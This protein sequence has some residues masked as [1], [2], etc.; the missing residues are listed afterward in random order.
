MRRRG[1]ILVAVLVVTVLVTMVAASLLFRM[2]A[3]TAA[4]AAKGRGDQAYEA[5]LSGLEFATAVLQNYAG[6]MD[7]WYDN[8]D[9][10]LNQLVA[11]DGAN[12]WYFTVY[13]DDPLGQ[14]NL[15]YG[16]SDESGKINLNTA[17]A[18]QLAGLAGLTEELVDCLLDYIDAD[19]EAR[20]EGAEQEYYDSLPHP[21]VIPNGPLATIEELLLVKGFDG[22]IVYGEDA[23]L[24]GRLDPNEDDGDETFPPDD[25]DGRL[26]QGLRGVATVYSGDSDLDSE[27]NARI[28]LNAGKFPDDLDLPDETR[29]FIDIYL[30]EGNTFKHPSELLDMRYKVKQDHADYADVPVGTEIKSG[31]E[32]EE[33]P[34]VMDRLTTLASG[35]E[36]KGAATG[37]VNVS[38]A[39]LEVLA[40]LPGLDPNLAQQVVDVRRNLDG[41]SKATVAWLYAQNLVDADAFKKLAP[42]VTARSSQ[43]SLRCVGFGV[44]CGRFRVIEA[45]L[46][47]AGKM[48]RVLYLRDITRLGLPFAL[49]ADVVERRG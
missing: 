9:I 27:G 33:L 1:V 22:T 46:D 44:P 7:V 16:A 15:R 14:D 24:N 4:S 3:E 17:T 25:S 19:S 6:D 11:E 2:R 21:Y 31:V 10:F 5:A 47:L 49:N 26:D 39:P 40:R 12:T 29:R 48:P 18:E 20:R 13:G 30:A 37:L 36:K 34:L 45:V 38:T 8:P 28:D 41:K 43:F 23:N 32:A 42:L 35:G